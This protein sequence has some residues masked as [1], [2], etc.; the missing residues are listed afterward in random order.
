MCHSK[1]AEC[2]FDRPCRICELNVPAWITTRRM[3]SALDLCGPNSMKAF[4][5]LKSSPGGAEAMHII[6]ALSEIGLAF[7]IQVDS[8][9]SLTMRQ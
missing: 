3:Q 7:P 2:C 1:G 9:V 6:A 4:E 8:S 5:H